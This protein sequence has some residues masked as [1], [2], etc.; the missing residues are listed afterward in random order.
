MST[1]LFGGRQ[2]LDFLMVVLFVFLNIL[3]LR[4]REHLRAHIPDQA[5]SG[6]ITLG[7]KRTIQ[8]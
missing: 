5:W 8:N 6:A 2:G 4:S 7:I 1:F 3:F